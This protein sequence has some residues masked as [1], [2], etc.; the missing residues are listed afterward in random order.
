[1]EVDILFEFEYKNT[2]LSGVVYEP[3]GHRDR[4]KICG[5]DFFAKFNLGELTNYVI[6]HQPK[7]GNM[8]SLARAWPRA[9]RQMPHKPR[10]PTL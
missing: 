9:L 1:M 7:Y 8:T 5:V 10:K 6:R 4:K 2:C 3:R